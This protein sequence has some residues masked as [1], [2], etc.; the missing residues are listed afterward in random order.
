M[1]DV[2]ADIGASSLQLDNAARGF[3]FQAVRSE[4]GSIRISSGPS[5]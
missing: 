2:L 5:A 1:V 4:C 3:S